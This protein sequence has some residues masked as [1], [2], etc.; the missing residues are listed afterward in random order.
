MQIEPIYKQI[1]ANVRSKR[2]NL[3]WTQERLAA[4]LRI[5]RGALANI[6]S[7]RQR[8][9]IHQLLAIAEAMGSKLADMLPNSLQGATASDFASLPIP[10]E[11]SH[12]QK[13]Q[14]AQ[15][16]NASHWQNK[17]DGKGE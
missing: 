3:D 15:I 14:I 4:M 2:R 5:S 10:N 11:L 16:I 9:F 6:E 1:G 7:G 12:Q 13:S 8:I 17:T